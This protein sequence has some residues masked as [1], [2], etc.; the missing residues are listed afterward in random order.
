[1][2]QA[3]EIIDEIEFALDGNSIEHL[4]SKLKKATELSLGNRRGITEESLAAFDGL[5]D[6]LVDYV[7]RRARAE[8]SWDLTPFSNAPLNVI[9]RLASDDDIN[10]AGPVLALSPRLTDRS[11]VEVA[12][13]KGQPH[14]SKVAERVQLSPAVTDILVDRGD[15]KVVTKV[16]SNIGARF[17]K[18]GMSVLVKRASVDNALTRAISG[19]PNILPPLF[20]HLLRYAT[21]QARHRMLT[22]S[23]PADREAINRVFTQISAQIG[24]RAI[25]QKEHAAAGRLVHS[26]AQ[27]YTQ[28]NVLDF[29]NGSCIAELVAAISIL[30]GF[31]IALVSRVICDAEPFGATVL[32]KASRQAWLVAYGVL[33]H[34]P[35]MREDKEKKRSE[36][37]QLYTRMSTDSAYHLLDYWQ[38]CQARQQ[39]P[40]V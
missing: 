36:M 16:V 9:N 40:F 13:T 31:P 32:C 4:N 2:S 3:L 34:L 10:I 19:R 18:A 14:L 38:M 8:L 20:K 37:E 17:S 11:L 12:K 6:R 22:S 30:N 39:I 25:S 26:I 21:E 29:A 33:T 5:I 35:S 28:S 1:M 27:E 24:S 23:G 15:K 7:E